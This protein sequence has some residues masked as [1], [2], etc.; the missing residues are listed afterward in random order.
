MRQLAPPE[1]P[2]LIFSVGLAFFFCLT[3]GFG[4]A[5]ALLSLPWIA[6]VLG[7]RNLRSSGPLYFAGIGALLTFVI[8]CTTSSL[9]W[10]PLFIEDQTFFE[11]AIITA[12]RQGIILLLAGA[13]FG[14][15]YW[16]VRYSNALREKRIGP[17]A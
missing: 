6:V 16:F 15:I 14:L 4:L 11:G 3:D 9:S 17:S 13:M 10:K 5:L 12:E 1:R 7:Y 2:G 8:G